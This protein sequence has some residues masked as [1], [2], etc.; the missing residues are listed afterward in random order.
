MWKPVI[1]ARTGVTGVK[2]QFGIFSID[3]GVPIR[4]T[5]GFLE[6][7]L[8]GFRIRFLMQ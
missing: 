1:L 2:A 8:Q 4:F 5:R 7:N 3:S 6:K